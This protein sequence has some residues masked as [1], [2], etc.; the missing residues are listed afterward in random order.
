MKKKYLILAIILLQLLF[1]SSM[2]WFHNEKLRNAAR[3]LLKTVPYDPV[4]IFRGNYAALRYEISS[5]PVTLLKDA[6]FKDLKNGDELFVLLREK[7]GLWEAEAIYAKQPKNRG[8]IYLRGRLKYYYWGYSNTAPKHLDFEYGIESFFLN[9]A[10]AKE[11][12]R[13]NLRGIDWQERDKERKKRLSGLDEETRRIFNAGIAT[14][15]WM[16]K[17][18]TESD[19]WVKEGL[20]SAAAKDSIC[21]KY[22]KAVEKTKAIEEEL[23][24]TNQKPLFVEVAVDRNGYGYPVRLFVEGKEYR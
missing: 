4:S 16:N 24:S 3:I 14:E 22:A 6:S 9:E 1:L 17:L 5:L 21:N 7:R 20:I 23:S 2:I 18:N 8:G 11:V 15:W 12:D 10:R 19:V 13:L